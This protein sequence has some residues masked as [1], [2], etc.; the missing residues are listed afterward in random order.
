MTSWHNI[1]LAASREM[2]SSNF[3]FPTMSDTNRAIQSQKMAINFLFM[4]LRECTI[5]VAKTK[6]LLRCTITAQLICVFVFAYTLIRFC[7]DA[8]Q[9][10]KKNCDLRNLRHL[11]FLSNR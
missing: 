3:G 9:L 4:K 5:N 10:Q 1:N 2:L 11:L 8:A 6:V 7:H